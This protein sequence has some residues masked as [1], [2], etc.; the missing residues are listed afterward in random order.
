MRRLFRLCRKDTVVMQ[1][2]GVVTAFVGLIL[3]KPAETRVF[4][5]LYNE[6]AL[7]SRIKRL[8]YRFAKRKISGILCPNEKIGKA[9]SLPYCVVPDYIYCGDGDTRHTK[10]IPYAD[11]KYD[12]CMVGLIWRDKG[13]VEAARHLAKTSCRVLIAGSLSGEEGLEDDLRSACNGAEN[14]ELRLGYLS[15]E[16]YDDAIRNSRYCILNYSGAYSKHSSGVVFDILF[17]GVPV[18][19]RKCSTLD[20]IGEYDIGSLFD[21]VKEFEPSAVLQE[22]AHANFLKNLQ[23]Y[24]AIHNRY[25]KKLIQ[26][27]LK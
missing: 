2:S 12:F 18:I 9:H 27:V 17:R 19:G 25:K 4:M 21:N 8:I 16:E 7:N 22:T 6:E 15:E 3:F 23:S 14:I 10:T 20:F 24:F 26:F 11:K 5:I 13:M 1:S